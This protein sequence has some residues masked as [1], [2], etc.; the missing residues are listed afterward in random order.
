MS[1]L[2]DTFRH[3]AFTTHDL[4]RRGRNI[5]HQPLEETITDLNVLELSERHGSDV[6]TRTFTK[7]EEGVN[8]AD[9]EW[10]FTN[11]SRSSWLGMLVQAKIL[12]IKTNRFES[13]HYISGKSKELQLKK[14]R[15][16][17]AKNR[18][19][20]LFCFYSQNSR[21]SASIAKKCNTY[22]AAPESLGCTIAR[23]EHV[24]YL[25]DSGKKDN[26]CD[27]LNGAVPWHCL[28]CC[29]GYGGSSLP[30]RAW[31]F[32]DN[33]LLSYTPE[34]WADGADFILPAS[35]GPRQSAPS[36]VNT[37]LE[38]GELEELPSGASGILIITDNH[39]D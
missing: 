20:L 27:V 37:I 6:I 35:S 14:I 28:V 22:A 19:I 36:Y 23:A 24:Q 18:L 30:E 29:E 8:G 3:L 25:Y 33:R 4:I 9:W 2:C 16:N 1:D 15:D 17:A 26:Y 31:Q 11:R 7:R 21:K 5:G 12:K 38:N 32:M 39:Q 34:T 10:W 13:L